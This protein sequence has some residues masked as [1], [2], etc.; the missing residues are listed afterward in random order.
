MYT[1]ST[2]PTATWELKTTMLT[3]GRAPTFRDACGR[4]TRPR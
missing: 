4:A 1:A 3:S 2:L